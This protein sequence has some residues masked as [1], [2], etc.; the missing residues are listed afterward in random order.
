MPTDWGKFYSKGGLPRVEQQSEKK[1]YDW[2]K[3]YRRRASPTYTDRYTTRQGDNIF[4]IARRFFTSPDLLA[5]LNRGIYDIR[6]GISMRVPRG[7]RGG[8]SQEALNIKMPERYDMP[9]MVGQSI[10]RLTSARDLAEKYGEGVWLMRPGREPIGLQ[11]GYGRMYAQGGLPRLNAPAEEPLP[12]GVNMS[13]YQRMWGD[14]LRYT[15]M[16]LGLYGVRPAIMSDRMIGDLGLN[17]QDMYD[18]GYQ[19]VGD[20]WQRLDPVDDILSSQ[21]GGGGGGYGGGYGRGYGGGGG[22]GGGGR[23]PGMPRYISEEQGMYSPSITGRIFIPEFAGLIR[24][25]L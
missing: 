23:N 10:T 6:A 1:G 15:A 24:W 8:I 3:Y 5:R 20:W 21:Y 18:L 25:R 2:E 12:S 7:V 11:T 16:S 13:T 22:G 4:D 19:K 9:G 17:A 14:A